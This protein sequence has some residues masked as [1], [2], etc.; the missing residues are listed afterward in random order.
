MAPDRVESFEVVALRLKHIDDALERIEKEIKQDFIRKETFEA[1]LRP[2]E[3]ISYGL[4]AL[5]LT[6]IVTAI[7][8]VVLK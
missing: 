4:V 1:R 6:A 7:V 5:L 8:S 3:W 2:L